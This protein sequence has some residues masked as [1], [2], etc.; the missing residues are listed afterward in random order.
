[1][2]FVVMALVAAFSVSAMATE[3]NA[4]MGRVYC[5][6]NGSKLVRTQYINKTSTV[7]FTETKTVEIKG[8]ES[9]LP[10]VLETAAP[11]PLERTEE[12]VYTMTH[13][14]RSYLLDTSA[15]PETQVLVRLITSSCR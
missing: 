10:K 2:K 12:Y 14:G 11:A 7:S 13:E 5:T 4:K 9:L 1:M 8:I 3:L 6:I 15:S